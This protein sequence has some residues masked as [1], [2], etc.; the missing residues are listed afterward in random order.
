MLSYEVGF[1][2]EVVELLED[3]SDYAMLDEVSTY[4][5]LLPSATYQMLLVP[6]MM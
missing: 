4:L 5:S 6:S 1:N 2:I 3:G